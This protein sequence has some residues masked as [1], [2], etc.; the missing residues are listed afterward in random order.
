MIKSTKAAI[1]TSVLVSALS[2][3][4]I[5]SATAGPSLQIL[6]GSY[7][8]HGNSHG[9]GYGYG[10]GYSHN[11]G[12]NGHFSYGSHGYNNHGYNTH[13][14]YNSHYNLHL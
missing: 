13:G 5:S 3:G 8:T 4:F 1:L 2:F 6:H 12:H 11:N 14:N 9:Y 10:H 7:N